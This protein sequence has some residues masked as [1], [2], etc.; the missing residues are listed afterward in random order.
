M[1]VV[2]NMRQRNAH[3]QRSSLVCESTPLCVER[4]RPAWLDPLASLLCH[5]F[6]HSTQADKA[7]R[8]HGDATSSLRAS[9][10]VFN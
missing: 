1:N 5:T 7:R 3:K 4:L 10:E 9:T 6:S 2:S 8:R